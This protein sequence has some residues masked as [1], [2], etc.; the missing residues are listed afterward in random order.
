MQVVTVGVSACVHRT[1]GHSFVARQVLVEGV[2]AD[3]CLYGQ[4]AYA[5]CLRRVHSPL[6]LVLVYAHARCGVASF[7]FGELLNLVLGWQ[8]NTVVVCDGRMFPQSVSR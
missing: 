2:V 7:M 1:P 4:D 8:L 5:L 6:V 3:T